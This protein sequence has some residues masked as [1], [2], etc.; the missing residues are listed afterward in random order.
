MQ[1]VL[2]EPVLDSCRFS[3]QRGGLKYCPKIVWL[4]FTITIFVL[5]CLITNK[6][7]S[8]L[9]C[10]WILKNCD[11]DL[12]KKITE[13]GSTYKGGKLSAVTNILLNYS[14]FLAPGSIS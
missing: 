11:I 6:K 4:K 2:Y 1:N 14:F 12:Y 10:L 13:K 5:K 7:K 8:V 3:P 9:L